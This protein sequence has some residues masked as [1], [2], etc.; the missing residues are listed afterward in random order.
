M[1]SLYIK[2]IIFVKSELERVIEAGGW[3]RWVI[4][5]GGRLKQVGDWS[6]WVIEA[7]GSPNISHYQLK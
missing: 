1:A 3:S 7:G 5:A 2:Q 6:R 4:E